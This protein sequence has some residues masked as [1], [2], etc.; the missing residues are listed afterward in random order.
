LGK[1][2]LSEI[3]NETGFDK[4]MV[5]RYLSILDSIQITKK[6]IPVTE[7]MP[8]KSRRGIYRIDDNFVRFWF[9]FVFRNRSF[10][11]E[12]RVDKVILK[13][14]EAMPGLLAEN[15]ERIACEILKDALIA[16]RKEAYPLA[17]FESCGRWWNKSGE[18]D[19]VATNS[20]TN[21]I[22]FGEVKWSNKPVGTNIY[23]YL[24]RTSQAVDWGKQGRKEYFVLFSKSGFTL[25][26]KA[27]A[28]KERV[29][30]FHKDKLL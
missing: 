28:K 17:G 11:E 21:E 18:I 5:S 26:M 10:L 9:R 23:E 1:H 6:E 19:L 13:V 16:G 29:Y 15:Y 4:G 14:R 22:I 20:Q 25:A 7:K 3:I 27:K 24:K 8:E 12:N 30:L 2:K